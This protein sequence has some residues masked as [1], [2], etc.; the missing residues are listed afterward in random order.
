MVL[1]SS[2]EPLTVVSWKKAVLLWLSDKVEILEYHSS[3]VHSAY[4]QF[5]LPSVLR[6][7][8][9]ITNLNR[10]QIR[11]CRENIYLRDKFQCQYCGKVSP[12]RSLT[13]DHVVPLSKNG[14][15]SWEN[16]V[17]ACQKCNNL[18]GNRTPKQALMP[19]LSVPHVPRWLPGQEFSISEHFIHHTWKNYLVK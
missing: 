9:Y 10:N 6:F 16:V 15:H 4:Q 1:N 13:L 3:F 14:K 17:T 12:A 7:T 8:K 11:F 5:R 2:Y 19:L 18:K